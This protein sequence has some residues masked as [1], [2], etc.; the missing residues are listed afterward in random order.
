MSRLERKRVD[1][2]EDDDVNPESI[3]KGKRRRAKPLSFA[4][5]FP[6]MKKDR[7]EDLVGD[8]CCLI[9]SDEED[10]EDE[11]SEMVRSFVASDNTF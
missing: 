9:D 7:R 1:F 2:L 8:D 4:E 5:E 3:I 11:S 6:D 10:E